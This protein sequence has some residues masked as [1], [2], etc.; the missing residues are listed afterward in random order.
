MQVKIISVLPDRVYTSMVKQYA[1]LGLDKCYKCLLAINWRQTC[2]RVFPF[3]KPNMVHS[4][5]N[6]QMLTIYTTSWRGIVSTVKQYAK[7][8]TSYI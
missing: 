3:F 5:N 7:N 1:V 4:S 2:E 6:W 8:M